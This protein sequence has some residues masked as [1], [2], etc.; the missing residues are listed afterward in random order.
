MSTPS[1]VSPVRHLP[2]DLGLI[3]PATWL[4]LCFLSLA[5]YMATGGAMTRT[6]PTDRFMSFVAWQSAVVAASFLCANSWH[7]RKSVLSVFSALLII[8]IT[9][10][11]LVALPL[12]LYACSKWLHAA[13]AAG[14]A[15][16]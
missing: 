10:L 15:V 14:I 16:P 8:P 5:W 13:Q 4:T 2:F 9:A 3:G 12:N 6:V 1:S 11:A 7:R